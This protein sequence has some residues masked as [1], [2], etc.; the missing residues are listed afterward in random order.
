MDLP[1]HDEI[2]WHGCVKAH[3]ALGTDSVMDP[4]LAFPYL[5]RGSWMNDMNQVSP[6]LDKTRKVDLGAQQVTL[7]HGLWKLELADLFAAPTRLQSMAHSNE[8][9]AARAEYLGAPQHV[10][11]FGK[12]NRLD[13]LDV[14]DNAPKVEYD[15]DWASAARFGRA[16]TAHVVVQTHIPS[17]LDT[18]SLL[19]ERFSPDRLTVLGRALHSTADFFAHSNYVELLLWSLA[20]RDRLDPTLIK[21]FN[22]DNGSNDASQ[23]IF[24]CPLPPKG[25][26]DP[27]LLRNAILWYGASPEETPLASAVFD[28]SDTAFSLLH[29]YAH[30][31]VRTDGQ[32]QT[33]AALD[34]AMAIFDIQGAALIKGA[35]NI[36]DAVRDVFAAI[37]REARELLA[38]QLERS[39][40]S[41]PNA[42][43][44]GFM[45]LTA[46]LVRRY[47]QKEADDWGRAGKLSF[48]A[49]TLQLDMVRELQTQQSNKMQLAHHS[50]LAKDHVEE[51]AGGHLR[52]KLACL[53]ATEATSK[54][55]QWHFAKPVPDLADYD[56]LANSVMIHPWRILDRGDNFDQTVAARVRSADGMGRWQDETLDGLDILEGAL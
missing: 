30:R 36:L 40:N 54:I 16:H 29:M 38:G 10:N 19:D 15:A 39:A 52:F 17:R 32:D 9:V 11:G 50:L 6:L 12:Y 1:I 53:M 47:N 14:V 33:D 22:F 55:L 34:I 45:R 51:D 44:K 24:R 48:L 7:F 49:R 35:W 27:K 46:T 43:T 2:L 13:H 20:W 4:R 25:V 21:S 37:G 5:V 3:Q 56:R 8:L 26:R 41:Q 31:L 42:E 23:P 28:Q 18:S